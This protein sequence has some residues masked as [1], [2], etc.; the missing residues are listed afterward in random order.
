MQVSADDK[1]IL[2]VGQTGAKSSF[3]VD[4]KPDPSY[5][6]IDGFTGG[7][8]LFSPDA[9]RVAYVART[10]KKWSVVV[11]G[12]PG[13]AYD[14]II[15]PPRFS[16]DGKHVAYAA[17]KNDSDKSCLVVD[18]KECPECE[19]VDSI[20]FSPNS[21]HVAYVALADNAQKYFVVVDGQAGEEYDKIGI[22]SPAFTADGVVEYLA[23]KDLTLYRVR[24]IPPRR[25]ALGVATDTSVRF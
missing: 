17:Y 18:G 20:T 21:E 1:H 14:K 3:V 5:D 15:D 7:F 10:G 22:R 11:D 6:E 4:N 25:I 24:L 19:W 8:S 13:P 16:P 23:I 12:N 9:S 2:Y